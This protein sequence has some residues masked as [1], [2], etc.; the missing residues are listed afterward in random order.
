MLDVR[1]RDIRP[2]PLDGSRVPELPSDLSKGIGARYPAQRN[3]A[4]SALQGKDDG[5]ALLHAEG[6]RRE[7]GGAVADV[8]LSRL[9]PRRPHDLQDIVGRFTLS[10][11]RNFDEADDGEPVLK[12]CRLALAVTPGA[13]EPDGRGQVFF[14]S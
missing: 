3:S 1:P 6:E 4:G 10:E 12:H 8:C 9:G 7:L 11:V 13:D 5:V 14:R 2:D